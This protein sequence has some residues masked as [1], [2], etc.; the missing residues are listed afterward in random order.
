MGQ[1]LCDYFSEIRFPVGQVYLVVIFL[2]MFIHFLLSISLDGGTVSELLLLN[3]ALHI[4]ADE[5]TTIGPYSSLSLLIRR[6]RGRNLDK[7][8]NPRSILNL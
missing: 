2:M 8:M 4:D 3:V 6:D 1:S 7:V 5:T